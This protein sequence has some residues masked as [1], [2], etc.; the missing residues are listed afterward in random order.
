WSGD[1]TPELLEASAA[2]CPALTTQSAAELRIGRGGEEEF[3]DRDGRHQLQNRLAM[4]IRKVA[5]EQILIH[6][7][8]KCF[9]RCDQP[10][11]AS[12]RNHVATGRSEIPQ[13]RIKG[14]SI[15][16]ARAS[17]AQ[18]HFRAAA[19][20][21]HDAGIARDPVVASEHGSRIAAQENVV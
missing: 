13:K 19:L 8:A 20:Q 3:L 4:R 10:C 1:F 14:A 2:L 9:C 15:D 12:S 18:E 11:C 7:I 16:C 5:S 21:L 6:W 17:L